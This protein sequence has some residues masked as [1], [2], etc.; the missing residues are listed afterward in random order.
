MIAFTACDYF[1]DINGEIAPLAD[2]IRTLPFLDDNVSM[3]VVSINADSVQLR[4]T[5][6]SD[7]TIRVAPDWVRRQCANY[8]SPFT[9]FGSFHIDF[10][11]RQDWRLLTPTS[12]TADESGG[13]TIG[14]MDY[15]PPSRHL[16]F[17]YCLALQPIP[18]QG[19]EQYR[20]VLEVFPAVEYVTLEM[21]QALRDY[22]EAGGDILFYRLAGVLRHSVVA[23][24][25][26]DGD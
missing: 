21:L 4:I 26:W 3:E 15:V 19:V 22:R 1:Q 14:F 5:N 20:I 17:D 9:T 18:K 16:I 25:Y 23:E 2:S 24:F 11:D 7:I 6:N 13:M 8:P 12:H 10:F